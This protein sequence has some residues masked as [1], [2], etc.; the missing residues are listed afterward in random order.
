MDYVNLCLSMGAAKAEEIPVSKLLLQ[1]ELREYC[2]QNSCGRYGRNYT[3]PPSI[4]DVNNLIAE[5]K[6]F[7]RVIIWQNIYPLEDSFDFEGMMDA[8]AKHNAM[9]EKIARLLYPKVE[10]ILI[11][12]AGGC[13]I[14]KT[15]GIITNEPCR[16]RKHAFSSLEAYGINVSQIGEISSLKYINGPNTV[17]YF[18]GVFVMV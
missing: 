6:T 17:T 10:N 7:S 13:S 16:D 18:A 14:C 12:S 3:C 5:L 8:A 15:C 1:P 2:K 4:G 11:L 9:T